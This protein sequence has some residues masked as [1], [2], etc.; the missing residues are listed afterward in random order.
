MFVVT[1]SSSIVQKSQHIAFDG[2]HG[3]ML[4][5]FGLL[6]A[7]LICLAYFFLTEKP[8]VQKMVKTTWWYPVGAGTSSAL[9]NLFVILL[10]TRLSS[11][12]VY[13][14][15]AVGCLA[16]TSLGTVVLFKEKLAWWQWVGVLVGTVAVAL[17][18]IT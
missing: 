14:T 16:V 18:S 9:G 1:A 8:N 6:V 10:A 15:L 11:N 17:L 5:F 4:M 12:L 2:E 3:A 13:P 7:A